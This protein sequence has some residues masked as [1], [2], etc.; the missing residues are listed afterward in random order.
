MTRKY[1]TEQVRDAISEFGY[2]E[3]VGNLER[4]RWTW[5][6]DNGK[7]EAELSIGLAEFVEAKWGEEGGG[8]NVWVVFRLDGALYQLNGY[9]NSWDGTDWADSGVLAVKE[10]QVMQTIYVTDNE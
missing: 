6:A 1:T 4:G 3:F 5:R 8:E 9:Y 2:S 10:E 7:S